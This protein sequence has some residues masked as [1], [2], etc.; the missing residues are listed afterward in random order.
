MFSLFSYVPA[1]LSLFAGA[2]I[3]LQAPIN[4]RLGSVMGGPLVAAF[5]SF[6]TGTLALGLCLL[7][8]RKSV[9][10]S[11][12]THTSPWMWVGGVLGAILVF[13]TIF[14]VP[15]LGA[16]AM[17]ALV[18]GGQVLFSLILD[19]YG[20]LLPQAT[21]ISPLRLLGAG[22]LVSGIALIVAPKL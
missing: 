18:I 4:A 11:Q 14:A 6:L 19:H 5:L 12:I 8:L 3:V 20:F 17:F 9:A 21:A 7:V 1:L 2:M 16:T 13:T 15:R 22:L 10:I